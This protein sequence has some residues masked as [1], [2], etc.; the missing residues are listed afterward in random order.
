[1]NRQIHPDHCYDVD[2]VMYM[3]VPTTGGPEWRILKDGRPHRIFTSL[4]A[5]KGWLEHV[6]EHPQSDRRR[7]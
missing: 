2:G 6:L 1:M 5:A 7:A 3:I 4:A